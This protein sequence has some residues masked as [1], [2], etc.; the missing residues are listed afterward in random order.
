MVPNQFF[1]TSIIVQKN[2]KNPAG[3][4]KQTKNTGSIHHSPPP[5]FEGREL[6]PPYKIENIYIT[7]FLFLVYDSTNQSNFRSSD[8]QKK[9]HYLHKHWILQKF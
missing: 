8:D 6:P 3:R 9:M 7:F 4:P 1:S 5:V 2:L